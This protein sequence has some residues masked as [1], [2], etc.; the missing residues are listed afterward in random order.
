MHLGVEALLGQRRVQDVV[1]V[2]RQQVDH[3]LVAGACHR[4]ARVVGRRPRVGAVGERAVG[5]LVEDALVRVALR[6]HEDGML[7]RVRQPVVLVRPW[8]SHAD[9]PGGGAEVTRCKVHN[10]SS[11]S[12]SATAAAER[13]AG[14]HQHAAQTRLLRHVDLE[15][16]AAGVERW[17][18]REGHRS[19][20]S[21]A[22]APGASQKLG[23][24]PGRKSRRA[25]KSQNTCGAPNAA[26]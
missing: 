5:Q 1:G 13:L 10:A 23:R 4:V 25:V 6:A 8:R 21:T 7:E 17:V 15:A 2:D 22:A 19:E 12:S 9:E 18:G 24:F 3:A 11:V 26:E 14:L 16:R 20:A